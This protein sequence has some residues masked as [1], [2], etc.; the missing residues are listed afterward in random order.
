MMLGAI[1]LALLNWGPATGAAQAAKAPAP[2]ALAKVEALSLESVKEGN[3]VVYYSKGR[4]AR[5]RAVL[6]LVR[7]LLAW[8]TPVY[9]AL[10]LK[11]AV[12]NEAD[13]KSAIDNPYGV[14]GVRQPGPIAFMPADVERGTLYREVLAL[15]DSLPAATKQDIAAKCGSLS[16]CTLQF[17]DLIVLHEITHVYVERTSFGRPNMWVGELAPDYLVYAYL[18]AE[19]RPE[20]AAWNVMNAVTARM[21]PHVTSLESL[22]HERHNA[23]SLTRLEPE[24]P[25]LHGILMERIPEVY[26]RVGLDFIPRL[27]TTFPRQ[28]HPTGCWTEGLNAGICRSQ[29]LPEAEILHRLDAVAPGFS[30]WSQRYGTA[31]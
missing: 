4:E 8:C 3:T 22:E 16:A 24:L 12:L 26:D 25:R 21:T 7:G 29:E 10:D 14:P 6:A 19:H 23:N 18:R 28:E 20:L 2:T 17:A 30:A 27:A 1:L 31:R 15:A 5:G 11:V 13:W 9:G